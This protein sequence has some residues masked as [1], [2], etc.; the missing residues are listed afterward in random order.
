[1]K[2]TLLKTFLVSLIGIFAFNCNGQNAIWTDSFTQNA[3]PTTTQI[4]AWDNWRASLNPGQ[5][6][7]MTIKGTYD[8]TGI[9]CTD[10][11]IV[12]AFA[13]AVQN[14]TTYISASSNGV[15]WSICN[16][17]LGEIW[18]NPPSSCNGNNCPGPNAYIIRPGIGAGNPNWGGVNTNTCGGATQRMTFIF[19]KPSKPNDMGIASLVLPNICD[20]NQALSAKFSNYGT[21]K[22]DSFRIYWSVNGNTQNPLY[23]TS[24]LGSGKDTNIMITSSYS[25]S[26]STNYK[27][28]FWTHR[29]NNAFDSVASNDTLTYSF[30][31]LGNPNPPS[32]TNFAQCG[33]GIPILKGTPS[34][35]SDSI[36]WY[37]AST[38][39][40][41]LGVGSTIKGPYLTQSR[42]FYAQSLKFGGKSKLLLTNAGGFVI[43]NNLAAY[44]GSMFNIT[45]TNSVMVDS[46]IFRIRDANVSTHYL[47]YYKNGTH[48]GFQN[49]ANQW[50]LLNSGQ[51]TYF[52]T[53][54]M[55]FAKVSTKS[56]L[57]AGGQTY[58]FYYTTDPGAGGGNDIYITSGATTTNTPDIAL[59]GFSALSGLFASAGTFTP[60]TSNAE[61]IYT[62]VCSNPNRT[63]LLVTV[64]PRPTGADIAKGATFNGQ[65]RAG[66]LSTPD[67]VEV[68]NTIVYDILP[69]TGFSNA[70][71]GNTWFINSFTVQTTYGLTVPTSEYQTVL[72]SSSGN[73]TI[74]FI[75]T[76]AFLDSFI[77]FSIRYSDLGPHF[78]DST[79]RRT[80]VV[81]PTPKPN[82]KFPAS[83]CLGD[84]VLFDNTTT[85]HS[86][87]A[88]YMWY[89]GDNDSS[90]LVSPVHEYLAPG[91]YQVKL[92]AKSFPWNVLNDTTITVEV[93][94]LPEVKFRVNNQCEGLAVT[95]QNQSYVGNG[96]IIYDWDFGDNTPHSSVTNPSHLYTVPGGYKVTLKA[97]ANGCVAT[98]SKNAYTFARPDANFA[99][100]LADICA[101]TEVFMPNTSTILLG[102]Q[103]AFWR[104]GEGSSS[105][106]F[107][108]D[109]TYTNPGT[110]A[111]KLLAVSEF[112]CKDSITKNVTIKAS[113]NPDF[114]GNQFCGRIPTV[115]TNSTFEA[116]PNPI[117]NWTF[118]DGFTSSLKNLTRNWPFEGP[119]TVTLKATYSN[120]CSASKTEQIEVEIQPNADFTVQDICSGETA[121]FVNKST[122]DRGGI[123][124]SWD[125]GNGTYSNLGSPN[126]LFTPT[127]TTTYTVALVASYEDAC[128]DTAI[129]TITVS[130]SPICDF[131]FK[132]NGFLN[133]SFT[134]TIGTYT[135]YE[136]F[137]G[138][139]G[140]S[141]QNSPTYKYLYSGNFN[142]KMRAT[143]AA[144]C[145][146]EITKRV[147]ATTDVNDII[148][149]NGINIYPNP[150][151]GSFTIS[152]SQGSAM[153][154]EIFNILGEKVYAKTSADGNMSVNLN[155]NAKGIYLVKIT[156][157]GVTVTTKITVS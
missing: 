153:V 87:N 47:L 37:S 127:T 106:Q 64:K 27:L 130:E 71:H 122:G 52:T 58:G 150:N 126:R 105:T 28:K 12:N 4:T 73:G 30:L 51:I 61:V 10:K 72:P 146:C 129:K 68:G 15:I 88:S 3:A 116:I 123:Q 121:A 21:N 156:I 69:P 17:Y 42:T 157:N 142:V 82:F 148:A 144:G 85:I 134:P 125:F 81:A 38:G 63:A 95:F 128:S 83:I 46:I 49:Q 67:I 102:S 111:V 152:N 131:T 139:G 118:S 90:D 41:L 99:A 97:D 45:T 36:A 59:S 110:F 104:F 54:G 7:F 145:E 39:G 74:T 13:S 133:N 84:A 48:V 24:S 109:H 2:K 124:Y 56:L 100:P 137:F 94:E 141:T 1:M 96:T 18:L 132:E 136:W 55:Y 147:S 154:V 135:K 79:I 101:G 14:Y 80:F 108:G 25:F 98:L 78:C 75:P 23:V 29:P 60:Y 76:S 8:Q 6:T 138:E 151:N 40:T 86:G 20:Y 155:D 9:T 32:T 77:T 44:N 34:A 93:G 115:F 19:G 149:A 92:V 66:V 31:F 107:N 143:N 53:G 16:R 11:T 22:V 113:P 103:G 65:F 5:Y 140:T 120:G 112:D 62:K 91:I 70:G 26:A 33:V 117:Y 119:Y 89:F 57:L 43:S 35:S 114:S 50:T